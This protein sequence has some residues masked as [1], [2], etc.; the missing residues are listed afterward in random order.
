MVRGIQKQRVAWMLLLVA[1]LYAVMTAA[2]ASGQVA[3][4]KVWK[5]RKT[6]PGHADQV[7]GVA[8]SADLVAVVSKDGSVKLWDAATGKER[9]S[10]LRRHNGK[11]GWTA[12]SPDGRYLYSSSQ[13]EDRLNILIM[14]TATDLSKDGATGQSWVAGEGVVMVFASEGEVWAQGNG[15]LVKILRMDLAERL[16]GKEPRLA[17]ELT[18]L[19]GHQG[20]VR[21]AAF[22]LDGKT[23]VTGADDK[24]VRVW[25][26]ETGKEK[27]AFRGHAEPVVF[28]ASGPDGKIVASVSKDGAVKLGDVTARKEILALKDQKGVR[29]AGWGKWCQF[30]F[31]TSIN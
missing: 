19:K 28:V 8:C 3:N 26:V 31:H 22:S 10:A 20:Q 16:K 30:N 4:G 21:A 9:Y 27:S 15:N 13:E 18:T 25:D 12:F 7:L 5:E 6:L 11:I 23:V 29:C 14:D 1:S 17:E 2:G 24:T